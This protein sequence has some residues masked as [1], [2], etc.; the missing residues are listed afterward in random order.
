MN[1]LSFKIYADLDGY[2]SDP[3]MGQVNERIYDTIRELNAPYKATNRPYPVWQPAHVIFREA[4]SLMNDFINE[5]HPEEDFVQTHFFKVRKHLIDTY[6]AEIVL[7][8]DF[9]LLRL[10][11]DKKSHLLIS[12]IEN[13]V[14]V[15]SAYFKAFERL[16]DELSGPVV[17]WKAKYFAL[18]RQYDAL[19]AS[20]PPPLADKKKQ[21]FIPFDSIEAARKGYIHVLD[22]LAAVDKVKTESIYKVLTYVLADITGD[23]KALI[24]AA[25]KAHNDEITSTYISHLAISND[26]SEIDLIRVFL[27]LFVADYIID[28]RTGKKPT[29]KEYFNT[30][31]EL[32]NID[33]S[34]AVG[35]YSRSIQ[36]GCSEVTTKAIFLALAQK[37]VT[38]PVGKNKKKNRT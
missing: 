28:R 27:S 21:L 29:Q 14:D 25:E 6:A 5:P 35:I 4:Y 38:K 23:F 19:S 31:G 33:L 36:Q 18:Q 10:R 20:I 32:F 8:V 13:A 37:L 1:A 26:L 15:N 24:K 12:A 11:D 3:R 2:L 22:L 9:T 17:D 30:I 34:D 16:A 7:S